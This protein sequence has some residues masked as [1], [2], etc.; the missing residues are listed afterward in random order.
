MPAATAPSAPPAHAPPR[1]RVRTVVPMATEFVPR[2]QQRRIIEHDVQVPLVVVAGAGSGKTATLVARIGWLVH[3]ESVEPRN[4]LAVTFSRSAAAELSA[5]LAVHLGSRGEEVA[6]STFH[7]FCREMLV[8]H[9]YRAEVDPDLRVLEES[10]AL[11]R[12]HEVHRELL[13]GKLGALAIPSALD[14]VAPGKALA[15]LYRLVTTAT[16]EG[17]SAPGLRAAVER[18]QSRLWDGAGEP[19]ALSITGAL[20]TGFYK[21]G[22]NAGEPKA[23]E[24]LAR[25][26]TA[27][28]AGALREQLREEAALADLVAALMERFDELLAQRGEA[29]YAHLIAHLD[30]LLDDRER[31][32]AI[33]ARFDHCVVDEYQDTNAAQQRL[34]ERIF[35]TQLR[36]VMLVGD[37]RQSIYGFRNAR[38]EEIERLAACHVRAGIDENFRSLQPILDAAHAAIS[39]QRPG[40]P[41]LRAL[42]DETCGGE[43]VSVILARGPWQE[44]GAAREREAEAIA[45]EAERLICEQGLSRAQIAILLRSK[46]HAQV[47]VQALARHAIPARTTGGV[48]FYETLEIEEAL[49]WLRFV[50]DPTDDVALLRVLSSGIVGLNEAALAALAAA[51]APTTDPEERRLRLA[52]AVLVDPLPEALDDDARARVQTLRAIAGELDGVATLPLAEAAGRVMRASGLEYRCALEAQESLDGQQALSNLRRLLEIAQSFARD[53]PSARIP[54]FLE[55][56]AGLCEVAFDEREAD[57]PASDAVTIATIH[58]AKGREWP[59]V[60]IADVSTNVFPAYHSPG[61]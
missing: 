50:D 27:P 29:T 8:L 20:K 26:H 55:Y 60:F 5:R 39:P 56:L 22:P 25:R 34:L 61:T 57:P 7:A 12:F 15:L 47:Y 11:T 16:E 23:E 30:R 46:T 32:A 24:A 17:L 19:P 52:H 2:E 31:C 28:A 1:R 42:R 49:A 41:P 33:R 21:K 6:V 18:A 48:G 40:E 53:L 58:W 45:L 9:A 14:L 51:S 13:D 10:E 4:I 43:E 36:G 3:H 59:A 35:G 54:E 37:P 44:R 38:P